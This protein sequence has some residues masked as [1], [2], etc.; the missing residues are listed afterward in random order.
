MLVSIAVVAC[1]GGSK[2]SRPAEVSTVTCEP[3]CVTPAWA[4]DEVHE[5]RFEPPDTDRD[6]AEPALAAPAPEP[7][8]RLAAETLV[9]IELGNY[10]EPD[11]RAPHVAAAEKRCKAARLTR[12]DRQ[13]L[14][15][16]TNRIDAAYC[17]PGWFPDVQ[18]AAVTIEQCEAAE[19]QMRAS[20]SQYMQAY[21]QMPDA[22]FARLSRQIN[23]AIASCKQDRWNAGL[24]Q[25][26]MYYVPLSAQACAYTRPYPMW[27]R[28]E[29]RL[30]KAQSG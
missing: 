16:A 23:A 13:C 3:N 28:L 25:C 22:D 8:C 18:S 4:P 30:E 9:S 6:V 27:K 11:E 26:A 17:M 24:L 14:L 1:G 21:P 12:D 20:L 15:D 5:P 19:K 10:A 29:A 2:A 7:T